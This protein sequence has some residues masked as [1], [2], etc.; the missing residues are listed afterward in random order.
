MKKKLKPKITVF[1][2]INAINNCESLPIPYKDTF[3]LKSVKM[4]CSSMVKDAFLLRAFEAGSDAV[5]VFVCPEGQCRYVEGNIRAKNRVNWVKNLL[6]EIEIGGRRLSIHNIANGDTEAAVR[7]I[8]QV[9]ADI[10]ELGP[11]PAR[12]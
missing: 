7:I 10:N 9:L 6:D 1:H 2:C 12:H 4:A 5:I 11:N 3:K 8:R